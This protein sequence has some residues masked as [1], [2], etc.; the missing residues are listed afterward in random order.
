MLQIEKDLEKYNNEKNIY[1]SINVNLK[2]EKNIIEEES[3][4]AFQE[5]F[6]FLELEK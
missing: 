3:K 5:K 6:F 1:P 2:D 4:K